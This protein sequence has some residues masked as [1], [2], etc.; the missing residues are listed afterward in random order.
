M[1]ICIYIMIFAIYIMEKLEHHRTHVFVFKCLVADL[2]NL[3]GDEDGGGD[4]FRTPLCQTNMCFN[5]K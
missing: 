2:F 3:A 4:H 5:P 1:V